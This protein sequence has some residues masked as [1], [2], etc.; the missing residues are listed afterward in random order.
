MPKNYRTIG[1]GRI[2]MLAALA[3]PMVAHYV[4]GTEFDRN[5]PV[6][7][8]GKMVKLEW[9]NPHA[10]I[11]LEIKR[12]DG[13]KQVRAVDGERPNVPLQLSRRDPPEPGIEIIVGGYQ[14]SDHS[15]N[16]ASGRDVT[17]A[18]GSKNLQGWSGTEKKLSE[19]ELLQDRWE[20]GRC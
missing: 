16:H 14:A 6:R 1:I 12:D 7:R 8:H 5:K 9:V 3:V 4:L 2:L 17:F 11:H 20:N 15:L 13:T 19:R 10:W 18:D